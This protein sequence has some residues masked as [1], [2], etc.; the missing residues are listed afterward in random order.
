MTSAQNIFNVLF[1]VALVA[2]G[3]L[4]LREAPQ[5][6][7]GSG[8]YEALQVL[9]GNGLTVGDQGN[10]IDDALHGTCNASFSGTSLAASSSG[11]FFCS[12]TGARSG[13]RVFVMLP[14]GAGAHAQGAGSPLGGFAASTGYATTSDRIGFNIVNMTGAATT[15]FRQA[16]T[17]VQYWVLR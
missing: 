3:A 14:A 5:S 17:S 16:T 6:Y 10:D 15:S 1:V 13:D 8:A 2:V 11:Q 9:Y 4:G 12:V 7:Q